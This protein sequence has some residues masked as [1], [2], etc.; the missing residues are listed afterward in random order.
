MDVFKTLGT[1]LHFSS[2]DHPQTNGQTKRVNQIMEDMLRSHVASRQTIWEER[3]SFV[4]FAYNNSRHASTGMTPF[5]PMYGYDPLI[6]LNLDLNNFKGKTQVSLEM[7]EEMN[8]ELR[9]CKRNI[10][11]V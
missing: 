6:P 4:E 7:L 3:L 5:R 8:N 9:E 11:R 2:G 10:E 1:Q